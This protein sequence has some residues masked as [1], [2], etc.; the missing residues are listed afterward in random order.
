MTSSG[1][2]R[3]PADGHHVTSNQ[4]VALTDPDLR[5]VA[6]ADGVFPML[7]HH[8]VAR[9]RVSTNLLHLAIEHGIYLFIICFQVETVV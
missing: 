2:S 8:I 6:V 3:I 5:Q 4:F 9:A 7:Q 1:A